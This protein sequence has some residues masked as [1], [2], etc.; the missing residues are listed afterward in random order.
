MVTLLLCACSLQSPGLEPDPG[1]LDE[2]EY[3]LEGF[4]STVSMHHLES[5]DHHNM[6][7]NHSCVVYTNR[8]YF[9]LPASMPLVMDS[10]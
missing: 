6:V 4:F 2:T 1:E 10:W 9:I 5:K 8:S 7:Y 3:A